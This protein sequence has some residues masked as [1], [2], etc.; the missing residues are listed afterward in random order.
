MTRGYTE[1]MEGRLRLHDDGRVQYWDGAISAYRP[2]W[3]PYGTHPLIGEFGRAVD[4]WRRKIGWY[5]RA[6]R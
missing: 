3:G 1:V 4:M 5:G 6:E 2:G